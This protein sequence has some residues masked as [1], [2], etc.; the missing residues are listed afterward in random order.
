[1]ARTAVAT[2]NSANGQ[3][4]ERVVKK[5]D[6]GF[7]TAVALQDYITELMGAQEYCC[8][9][10]GLPLEL[11]EVNGDPAMFA[12]LD[13]IDSTGHYAPSNLQVVC[14]FANFWKGASDDD[15]FRRLVGVLR[16]GTVA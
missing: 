11:D 12:S 2:T 6:L 3:T 9:L 14:R 7:P 10:T 5:K 8:E 15:E 4:V 1:M 13:R 16:S